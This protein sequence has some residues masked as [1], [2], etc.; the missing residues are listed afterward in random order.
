VGLSVV[1]LTI[2]GARVPLPN[3]PDIDC[4]GWATWRVVD[5]SSA[6]EIAEHV[7]APPTET[8]RMRDNGK[9]FYWIDRRVA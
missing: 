8:W 4:S 3:R 6:E 1:T 9:F 2:G 5:R 7:L